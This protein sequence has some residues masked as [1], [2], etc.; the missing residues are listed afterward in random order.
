MKVLVF[1][2]T[3]GDDP[4]MICIVD[5]ELTEEQIRKIVI[6][7]IGDDYIKDDDEICGS[8]WVDEIND[9]ASEIIKNV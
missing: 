6:E 9:K 4:Y 3:S 7:S 8:Y 5:I 2:N 1:E